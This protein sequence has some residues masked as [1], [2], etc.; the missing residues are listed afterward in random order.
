[1][2]PEDL[3]HLFGEVSVIYIHLE[4]YEVATE[5]YLSQLMN[6]RPYKMY[7]Y[8]LRGPFYSFYIQ[9]NFLEEDVVAEASPTTYW[10]ALEAPAIDLK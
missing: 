8:V 9:T 10:H 5:K 7:Y 4:Y 6:V 2:I 3:E 1:M